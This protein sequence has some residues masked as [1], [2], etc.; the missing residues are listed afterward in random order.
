MDPFI[1]EWLN[2]LLRW[3]HMIAGIAWIGTSFYF[4]ALDF[5]LKR[6]AGL[7]KGVAGE[8]WEVHGGGFYH[9]RKYISAPEK[10]PEDLIWFKWEA[11][12]TWVTGF[13]LLV[14]QYYI[15]AS[16]YLIDPKVLALLPWQAIAIS[17]ASL[18]IGWLIYDVLCRALAVK[19]PILLATLVFIL[20]M[21]A[22]YGYTHVYSGRGAFIHIGVFIG[23]IMAANVFM[24][25]IP[26]QRKITAALIRGE[27]PDP[28]FGATGKQRS[29][30]NT[31]LTLPVLVM[32]VSNHFAMVTDHPQAWLLAGLIVV[33]GVALR[34]FLVR[35]EVGDPLSKIAWTLPII[36]M[37][38]ALS[39]FMTWTGPINYD[40]LNLFLRWGH[41][42]A[43]I[44]WIG[45]SF[46][47]V[48]LDFSLRK[49]GGLPAGVAGEA[50]EVHGGGFY[51][52]QKYLTA[53]STLPK[54]LIWFKWEAYLTWV[55][56]FLLLIVLYYVNAST[57]L[58]DPSVMALT[59]WQAIAI[60]V[61]SL[62]AGWLIYDLLCRSPLGNNTGLLAFIVFAL[63]LAAAWFFTH[64]FS[65]RG[66]LIH[67]GAFV[68]TIMAANVFMIIIPNQRKITEALL[69][70][71]APD[72]RYG[73]IG[74][75]RS[76]HNTYLTLPV[77]LMM[78]SNHYPMI[79]DHPMS[80][81]L[82]GLIVVGG[83]SLRHFLVRIEVGDRQEQVAWTVPLIGSALAFA[84]LATQPA[85]AP[86]YQ[87]EVADAEAMSIVQT[88]CAS[89]HAAQPTDKTIKAAPKG[90]ALETL[91]ELKRYAKQVEIQAVN[92]KAMP[93]GN[94]TGMTDEER[95]KL[96][97]WIFKL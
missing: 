19:N 88:R 33:G 23:T 51:N 91:E 42:I 71:G 80:W 5:S 4:V 6:H 13:L 35:Y 67:V 18:A 52:I 81:L 38:F 60:S 86:A 47:F 44:A 62:A 29:L 8:A 96:G 48:A 21:M 55:T 77:L 15:N 66:A 72:P 93:L 24:V 53:P 41:M 58:I 68:G 40:W 76:L 49:R 84:L 92:S 43:G 36:A 45:T 26:N 87:G 32:M 12:L 95:A 20:V 73:V 28:N 1:A 82:V 16:A 30:H 75:Q 63:V 69:R 50:W 31:Y 56:G 78:V 9:V 57:Y 27:T 74:K 10:L 46:Y 79:T 3:G 59:P 70:G 11:Y 2:L 37:A 39:Y 65:G 97:A 7:P 90:I 17:V 64:V 34:H 85:T 94:K 54:D 14:V 89:C 22:A 83:A 61:V 25:I